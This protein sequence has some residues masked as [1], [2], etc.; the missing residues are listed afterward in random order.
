MKTNIDLHT[1]AGEKWNMANMIAENF[2]PEMV[3]MSCFSLLR[4]I[5]GGSYWGAVR[6]FAWRTFGNTRK[7]E[8]AKSE[9]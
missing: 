7:V 4:S 3:A 9:Q 1:Y 6:F 2:P 8:E 5:Y